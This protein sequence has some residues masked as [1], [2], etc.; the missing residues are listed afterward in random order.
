MPRRNTPPNALDLASTNGCGLHAL[1]KADLWRRELCAAGDVT[2]NGNPVTKPNKTVRI[3]DIVSL[4]QGGWQH[5]VRVI[6]LGARRGPASEARLLY[7]ETAA[8]L[9]LSTIA[10]DWVPLLETG[11]TEEMRSPLS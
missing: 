7:E 2:I 11:E 3:G 10:S 1:R 5:T 4:P 9:R 8:A 6:A